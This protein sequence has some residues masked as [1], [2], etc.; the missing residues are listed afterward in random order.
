MNLFKKKNPSKGFFQSIENILHRFGFFKKVSFF[1]KHAIHFLNIAQFLGVVNDNFFKYLIL[2]FFINLR[3]SH[4]SSIIAT[5]VGMIYVLP[6]LLFSSA[7]GIL[8]DRYNKQKIII[9]LKF[10]EMIIMFLGIFSFLFKTNWIP[11]LLLF[12]LSMQSALFGP[13]KYSII[14]TLVKKENISKANGLITSFT[15]LGV[16]TGTFLA[17]ALTQSTGKNFALSSGIG[18]FIAI[19]GF[20]ASVLIPTKQLK[21]QKKPLH[22]F[23]FYDIYRNIKYVKRTPYLF[24]AIC[25]S[26]S[27]LFFG[28]YFQLNLVPYAMQSMHFTEI[29]GGYLFLLTAVGIA[30]GAFFSGRCSRQHTEVGMACFSG[31]LLSICFFL[32]GLFSHHTILVLILIFLIGFCGGLYVVPFDTFIQHYALE[33]WRGQVIA[34]TNLLSFCGVFI[35]PILLY[36]FSEPLHLT[37]AQGFIFISFIIFAIVTL[38]TIKLLGHFLNYIAR[39]CIHLFYKVEIHDNSFDQKHPFILVGERKST[40]LLPFYFT[41]YLHCHIVHTTKRFMDFVIKPL[42]SIHFLYLDAQE[43]TELNNFGK[44]KEISWLLLPGYKRLDEHTANAFIQKLQK[45]KNI[46]VVFVTIKKVSNK[47]RGLWKRL[48]RKTLIFDFQNS[49]SMISRKA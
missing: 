14:P 40:L 43:V 35:A 49:T 33:K 15:Y 10:I 20:A 17:S 26:A 13:P 29:A 21:R 1:E 37:A 18:A 47:E 8:A 5:W 23:F 44:K 38:L 41:P 19:I 30:C 42:S 2:F 45:I 3:G 22:S 6:F 31:I 27:F 11:F 16:I 9:V 32:I 4:A 46:N 24:M 25:G 48:K 34:A 36:L 39:M 28:A 12:L 7:A